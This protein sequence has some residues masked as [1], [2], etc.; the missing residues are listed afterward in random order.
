MLKLPSNATIQK[1]PIIHAPVASQYAG[2]KVP[3]VVYVSSKTPFM[4]A[5]KR[6]KKLLF[7]VEKRATKDVSMIRNGD[8]RGMQRIAEASE[9]VAKDKEEVLVKASG[10]AIPK[11][12]NV[13]EWFSNKEKDMLCKVEVR[14]GSVSVVD[15][16]VEVEAEEDENAENDDGLEEPSTVLEGGETTLELLGDA[17]EDTTPPKATEDPVISKE[18]KS[19]GNEGGGN[20]GDV[21][22][23]VVVRK[24]KRHRKRKRAA[25]D[26]DDLPESRLRWVKTV[27]VAISLRG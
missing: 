23:E 15:D 3:K 6:V 25:H 11:A 12:L 9:K 14:G 24:K 7:H 13:G 1:R 5:V 8:R 16:I 19:S 27:E 2:A 20:K 17:P 21:T 22:G 10:R 4:S 26:A 18:N